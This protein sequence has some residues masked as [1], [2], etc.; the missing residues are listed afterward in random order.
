MRNKILDQVC[1][2]KVADLSLSTE[3]DLVLGGRNLEIQKAGGK[4]LAETSR[5]GF[6]SSRSARGSVFPKSNADNRLFSWNLLWEKTFMVK[7]KSFNWSEVLMI[8]FQGY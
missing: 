2:A 3:E 6:L 4:V 7:S 1:C 8:L 5:R